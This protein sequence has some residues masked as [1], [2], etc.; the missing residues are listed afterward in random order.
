MTARRRQR[1]SLADATARMRKLRDEQSAPASKRKPAP[2]PVEE[3]E[4]A[5]R[6]RRITVYIRDG[7]Y[8]QARAAILNLGA[9]G[10]EPASISSLLDEALARELRRLAKKH[11]AGKPW[12][13]HQGR[14]PGGR[15]PK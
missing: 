1:R 15:L 6:R 14:L 12:P 4:P 11:R 10:V 13:Y 9:Q 7:L 8:Q 3:A 2:A 5:P